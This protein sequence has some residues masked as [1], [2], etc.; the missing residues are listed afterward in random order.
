MICTTL[1][2]ID[3][4]ISP[5]F[6]CILKYSTILPSKI[7]PTIPTA[8]NNTNI[9]IYNST[10]SNFQRYP[11]RYYLSPDAMMYFRRGLVAL[12]DK[13]RLLVYIVGAASTLIG[14]NSTHPVRT[15]IYRYHQRGPSAH[16]I[17][18]GIST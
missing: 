12:R 2:H 10:M 13:Y 15:T 7:L 5:M 8:L 6:P 11:Q 3:P 1:S 17:D 4:F 9:N 16:N 14:S 18:R